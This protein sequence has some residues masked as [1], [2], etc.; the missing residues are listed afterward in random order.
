MT[1]AR[2]KKIATETK[3]EKV[4]EVATAPVEE[5]D[6][7]KQFRTYMESYKI[8]NPVKYAQKEAELLKQLNQL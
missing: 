8:K 5:S 1:K 7:K 4:V 3:T 6:A 2:P